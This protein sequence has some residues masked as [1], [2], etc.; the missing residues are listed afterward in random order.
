MIKKI[1]ALITG[2]SSGIGKSIAIELAKHGIKV[3]I[4]F[5]KS[6]AKAKKVRAQ[7]RKLGG[8]SIIY[9]A[10]I[11]IEKEV[12]KLFAFL[13][14]EFKTLDILIN[15][16]GVY[17]PDFIE[18]QDI[19]N[20]EKT[21]DINLKGKLLC[22]KYAIPLLRRSSSPKIINIASRAATVPMKESSAYCC[23]SSAIVMLTKVSALELSRYNIKVNAISP[24]LTRTSMTTAVD[25]NKVFEIYAKKNPSKRIGTPKDIAN[26]V[27]FLISDK[28]NFINGENIN[29]SGGIMLT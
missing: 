25:T 23:A 9:K 22:T 7:I 21:I 16:A 19:N 3:C 4:N 29:V 5:S 28:V 26:T 17:V 11:S 10:D 14:K 6:A 24:G 8:S 15:N 2:S 20:W 27:L 18:N 1:N 12:K 13:S